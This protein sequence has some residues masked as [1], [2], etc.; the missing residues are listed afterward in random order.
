MAWFSDKDSSPA[1]ALRPLTQERIIALFESEE[2]SYGIDD[3]GD[4]GGRWGHTFFYFFLTG[5]EK[6]ILNISARFLMPIPADKVEDTRLFIEDWHRDHYWPKA[7]TFTNDEGDVRVGADFA[8]DYE[9]GVSDEQ[10]RRQARCM[11]GTT[12]QLTEALCEATGLQWTED[13]E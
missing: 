11:I 10:L 4:L 1:S 3:D 2:W 6:E 13:E 7:F 5:P 12:M 9:H 8:L